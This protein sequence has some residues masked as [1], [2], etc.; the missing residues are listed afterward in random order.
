M[1]TGLPAPPKGGTTTQNQT[2]PTPTNPAEW[3]YTLLLTMGIDPATHQNSLWDLTAQ[4]NYEWGGNSVVGNNPLA[5]T[6]PEASSG[7]PINSIGVQNYGT[8][9]DGILGNVSVLQ[10]S[11]MAPILKALQDNASISDYANALAAGS[12]E[13][14]NP[15]ASSANAAYGQGVEAR[16]NAMLK[17]GEGGFP[18]LGTAFQDYKSGGQ[19]PKIGSPGGP[20]IGDIPQAA[21]GITSTLGQDIAKDV[22]WFG[23]IDT[24][25]SDILG[26]FGIG[27]KAVLTIIGGILLIGVALI[28]LFRKQE[29]KVIVAAPAAAAA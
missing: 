1:A 19:I 8:I 4:I 23:G 16:Y 3:A 6:Q 22:P 27:W 20:G 28:L 9:N 24:F 15:A 14:N 13:G 26:G 18:A 11:N 25:F 7:T 12:W 21:A 2:F 10:Q 29:S 5:S 17:G